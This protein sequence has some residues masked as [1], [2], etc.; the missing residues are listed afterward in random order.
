MDDASLLANIYGAAHEPQRLRI[1]LDALRGRTGAAS[2]TVHWF[3]RRADRLRHRW[4]AGCSF[5]P[6]DFSNLSALD[7]QNPRTIA[8]FNPVESGVVVLE[9]EL[10]P[11]R[12]KGDLTLWQQRLRSSGLG[13]FMGARMQMGALGEAGLAVHGPLDGPPLTADCRATLC[14]M[15]PHVRE[16]ITLMVATGQRE[17]ERE[18]L[19]AMLE[20]MRLAVLFCD[21]GGWIVG[22][23]AAGERLAAEGG[24]AMAEPSGHL[25]RLRL[26]SAARSLLAADSAGEMRCRLAGRDCLIRAIP[27]PQTMRQALMADER[28]SHLLVARDMAS[29]VGPSAAQLLETFGVTRGE[30]ELLAHLCMGDDL[31]AFAEVR[32]VSIHTARTQ[33]KQVMAKT[34]THRQSDLVRLL[35]NSPSSLFGPLH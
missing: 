31:R 18:Q 14:A 10:I 12:L 23:N 15:M 9:D 13:R 19:R 29:I 32:G 22:G 4:Q 3:N 25:R 8:A 24:I 16:A 33:L 30:A 17:Q 20:M 11:E 7:D 6:A 34:Q 35:M 26:S 2:V 5:T 27:L 21:V 1:A 28:A